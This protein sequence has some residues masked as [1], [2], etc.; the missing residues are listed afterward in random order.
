[1]LSRDSLSVQGL[2]LCI[3]DCLGSGSTPGLGIKIMQAAWCNN[4]NNR[5]VHPINILFLK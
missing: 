4:N 5:Y 1:M 3:L 2:G